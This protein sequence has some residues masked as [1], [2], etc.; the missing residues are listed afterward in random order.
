MAICDGNFT[1]PDNSRYS[2]DMHCLI[3]KYFKFLV[4]YFYLLS[5]GMNSRIKRLDPRS[6]GLDTKIKKSDDIIWSLK[7]NITMS[8]ENVVFY[9]W[10][11]I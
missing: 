2:Q 6:G 1:I 11:E 3:S 10:L 8:N 4:S 7:D 9:F 5:L